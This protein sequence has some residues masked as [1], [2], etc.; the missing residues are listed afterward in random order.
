MEISKPTKKSFEDE[1]T[2]WRSKNGPGGHYKA[3]SPG[4]GVG[5]IK[6]DDKK[7]QRGGGDGVTQYSDVT[8]PC[9]S[10]FRSQ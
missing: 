5:V 8:Y 4:R 3:T 10:V 7:W 2:F 1:L 6:N 9:L